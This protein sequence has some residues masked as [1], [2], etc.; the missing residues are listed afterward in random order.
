MHGTHV[1][2]HEGNLE[3]IVDLAEHAQHDEV[4]GDV[5]RHGRVEEAVRVI[6]RD[7]L[8]G[9]AG[10]ECALLKLDHVARIDGGAL[11]EDLQRQH[12]ATD[13]V[14]RTRTAST[15]P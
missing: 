7:G 10:D 8:H 5:G 13:A 3:P 14:E 9:D 11:G 1:Y 2:G 6:E 4:V 12:T 15:Q